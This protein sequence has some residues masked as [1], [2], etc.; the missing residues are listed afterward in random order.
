VRIQYK[1]LVPIYVF[2]EMKLLFPKQNY[3]VLSPSSYTHGSRLMGPPDENL[4][5]GSDPAVLSSPS[6][7]AFGKSIQHI[8]H[9]TTAQRSNVMVVS[10]ILYLKMF[11]CFKCVHASLA[12]SGNY[13]IM[14]RRIIIADG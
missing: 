1:F 4:I 5:L 14:P 9:Q 3:N 2:P 8:S 6:F 13:N 10:C 12:L 11:E 7:P